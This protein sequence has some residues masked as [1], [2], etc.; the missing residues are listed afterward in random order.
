MRP[1][2]TSF[3]S[4]IGKVLGPLPFT[5]SPSLYINVL[6]DGYPSPP[7]SPPLHLDDDGSQLMTGHHRRRLVTDTLFFFAVR[8]GRVGNFP[9]LAASQTLVIFSTVRPDRPAKAPILSRTRPVSPS[10]NF[11]WGGRPVSI[12]PFAA[13]CSN[14]NIARH[15]G[16]YR[17][18]GTGGDYGGA[19]IPASR[20]REYR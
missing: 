13:A 8:N 17:C 7:P 15:D 5:P 16:L 12:R 2:V 20:S 4:R 6:D 3:V 19:D 9:T 10:G 14:G 11:P 18:G 1:F